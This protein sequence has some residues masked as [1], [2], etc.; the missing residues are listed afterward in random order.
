ME[1]DF[2]K[3][4]PVC[5]FYY[6]EDRREVVIDRKIKDNRIVVTAELTKKI[7]A[8]NVQIFCKGCIKHRVYCT[9]NRKMSRSNRRKDI[10]TN[11]TG[12]GHCYRIYRSSCWGVLH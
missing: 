7:D 2:Q 12:F 11:H 3:S 1:N 9:P 5:R 10:E 4:C 6:P 8:C